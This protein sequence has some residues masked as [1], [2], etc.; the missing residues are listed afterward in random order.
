MHS[1]PLIMHM[2]DLQIT[3][4]HSHGKLIQKKREISRFRDRNRAQDGEE[5]S[6]VSLLWTGGGVFTHT[7]EG[8]PLYC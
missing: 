6:R 7:A 2:R 8:Q 3:S 5:R 1:V 4:Q